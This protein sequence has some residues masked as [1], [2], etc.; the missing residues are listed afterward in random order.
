MNA[1]Q[2]KLSK[3][4][5]S[6][7]IPAFNED[8]Y[9]ADVVKEALRFV[10]RVLVVDDGSSDQTVLVSKEAGAEV[11]PHRI[12][13]GKGAALRTGFEALLAEGSEA[14]VVLD[15]DGQHDPEELPVFIKSAE[16][17][18]AG[19]VLGNRLADAAGMPRVRYWT[20]RSMS[21]MLSWLIRQKIP[22]SQCGYRLIRREVLERLSFTTENYDMESEMLILASR[23]GFKI[24]SVPI[25][26]IYT[27]QVSEIK[28]GRDTLRFIKLIFK[29]LTASKL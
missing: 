11:I 20:N 9:I 29:Y 18:G 26:T 13:R 14:I 7:L 19:I 3:S 6:V 23:L 28:P 2:N 16:A 10:S 21:I 24:S 4:N 17:S 8:K 22:D 27:D 12:N 5:I 15:G 25:R 1:P